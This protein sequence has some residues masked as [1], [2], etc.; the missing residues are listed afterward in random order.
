[1][2]EQ[3]GK[4]IRKSVVH[5]VAPDP[6]KSPAPAA[7]IQS[8][9]GSSKSLLSPAQNEYLE[10]MRASANEMKEGDGRPLGELLDELREERIGNDEAHLND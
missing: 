1:M 8:N 6:R 2:G 9:T 4:N 5:S 7:A 10:N 3:T